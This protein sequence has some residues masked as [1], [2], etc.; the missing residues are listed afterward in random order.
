M[1]LE[2]NT[3]NRAW[4]VARLRA[5]VIGPDPSGEPFGLPENRLLTWE[6]FRAPKRQINGEEILWQDAPIKRY[7][8]GVLFPLGLTE[9]GQLAA[10]AAT[11]PDEQEEQPPGP[12]V[13]V[14]EE[15]EKRAV[16]KSDLSKFDDDTENFEI[17]LTNEYRPAALGLS[18]LADLQP[19]G[20]SGDGF[21]IQIECATYR[22]VDIRCGNDLGSAATRSL[23]YR[24]PVRDADGNHHVLPV[25]F[26][27]VLRESRIDVPVPSLEGRLNVT[28]VSRP[29]GVKNTATQRLVTVCLVNIQ[30]KAAGRIDERC[31]FQCALKVHSPS[32]IGWILPYPEYRRATPRPDDDD[33]IARLLYRGRKTFAIGH[34]C[35]VDW[36]NSQ[37]ESITAVRTECMPTFETPALSADV[38]SREGKPIRASMRTLAGLDPSDNGDAELD[39]LV[40]AY[41]SWIE[42]IETVGAQ[43]PPVPE[44]LEATARILTSR[45]KDCL[46]RIEDGLRFLRSD[47]ETA[48]VAREAFRLA[49]HAMLI[50]Q[51]RMSREVRMPRWENDRWFWNQPVK[52]IDP[53]LPH[54]W[55]GYWRAFQIAFL[56]MSLRGICEPRHQDRMLVDLIWFPTGGGKTE[57]YL[58]LTAFTIF[59]NRLSGGL[60]TS[61]ADVLMRY[62]LRLLTA[63]QF[64]RAGLLFCAMEHLRQQP[65]TSERLGERPFRLGMW[66][67]GSATPNTRSVARAALKRLHREPNSEN[68]FVLL[69]CPW[70][71]A[72]F[73]PVQGD[74][75]SDTKV[76]GYVP[77]KPRGSRRDTVI[78]RCYDPDCDFGHDPRK[79]GRVLPITVIDED[80]FDSPPNLVI[81]TVDKFAML[82]WKP[83]I[84]AIFGIGSEGEHTGLPPSL[85]IQDE[86]HLIS[87]PLG[88][89]V[90]AYE[91]VIEELCTRRG[92][93]EAIGPKIVAS[94][95]TISRAQEQIQSLYGRKR[96]MLFPPSGLEA[97]DSFFSREVSG[98]ENE[99]A[100]GR[101]YTGHFGAGTRVAPNHASTSIRCTSAIPLRHAHQR[102]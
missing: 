21:E 94:T 6:M 76:V 40:E 33:E 32:R 24:Q 92:N 77:R 71:H 74:G 55:R 52:Q 27:D 63:Q 42:R 25:S 67:G 46:Q 20:V 12:D 15:L 73:G 82:A 45:C 41:R 47:S 30:E 18:L 50:A 43:E 69:K 9:Q 59:F 91:T 13:R 62:T 96:T 53:S 19:G 37:G 100:S 28:I 7:G 70:C 36:E 101:L 2:R 80:I 99:P 3:A 88:S 14:D 48:E 51:L 31:F 22:R 5:E 66:V 97:G 10:E 95:A 60:N 34:G 72:K 54:P 23:W 4:L 84:R 39:G 35:A 29:H 56:L 68:P 98:S 8:A 16:K 89:M 61:G 81:G 85:I 65:G 64:Q 87:G 102:R 93:G 38:E 83:E 17:S 75:R 1:S 26:A 44:G 58:G 86:L 11:A 90:G 57:A 79:P 78:Y 49:N